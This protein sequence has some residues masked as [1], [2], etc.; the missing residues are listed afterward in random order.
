VHPLDSQL[1]IG[2]KIAIREPYVKISGG[3]G[4]QPFV[5]VDSPTDIIV[6]E[7]DDS[8]CKAL[9]GVMTG[10]FVGI[11]VNKSAENYKALG[12]T[13]FQRKDYYVSGGRK[14]IS[15]FALT[16]CKSA[17]AAYQHA[18]KASGAQKIHGALHSNVSATCLHLSKPGRAYLAAKAALAANL[19]EPHLVA[20]ALFR[21]AS[22][23]YQLRC[24]NEAESLF[25]RGLTVA[26]SNEKAQGLAKEFDECLARTSQRLRE[27]DTG[28][29]EF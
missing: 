22:A 26:G 6:L 12:N 23:A 7:D 5:R 25:K 21:Q 13:A 16:L 29:Y 4:G 3:G 2:T 20:K 1:P 11:Q 10:V 9:P 14:E 8:H 28:V 17:L 18:F 24:F 27:R 19:E 15:G